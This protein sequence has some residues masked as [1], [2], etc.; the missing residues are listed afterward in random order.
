M[1]FRLTYPPSHLHSGPS[2]VEDLMHDKHV[3][4]GAFESVLEGMQGDLKEVKGRLEEL[5]MERDR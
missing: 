1:F 5:R 3:V 4:T 2:Q